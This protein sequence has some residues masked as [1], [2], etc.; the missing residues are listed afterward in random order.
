MHV[1]RRF[2]PQIAT[3]VFFCSGVHQAGAQEKTPAVDLA[4]GTW[5]LVVEE[6][7][8]D[9]GPAPKEQTR[10]YAKHLD[11]IEATITTID[12]DGESSTINYVADYDSLEYP[13]AGARRFS[14]IALKRVSPYAADATLKHGHKELG[15][16]RRIISEDGDTM[17]ILFKTTDG[18][19]TPIENRTVFKR[20]R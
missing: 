5:E 2:I 11:G 9:P 16:A 18:E 20:V 15:F 4:L 1:H 17:V 10:R 12:A 6:S 8:Y 14:T 3:V 7:T 13:I 19:G